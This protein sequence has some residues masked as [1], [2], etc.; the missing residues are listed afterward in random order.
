MMALDARRAGPDTILFLDLDGVVS[1]LA[2]GRLGPL[3]ATWPAWVEAEPGVSVA[4]AMLDALAALPVERQWLSS[5]E[6]EIELLSQAIG[7]S[8]TP[9][10][11][12]PEPTRGWAKL[13][14][15]RAWQTT[16]RQRPII[17]VDDD[18]RIASSGRR[19]V[20][21]LSVPTLLVRP[22]KRV[23]LTSRHIAHMQAWCAGLVT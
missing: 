1:P 23:G 14:A 5:W 8:A 21:T 20:R 16:H 11:P 10:L 4:P 17:W 19:W 13:A 7:W 15:L 12:L 2:G 9:W 18:P 3:P 22:S 6:R